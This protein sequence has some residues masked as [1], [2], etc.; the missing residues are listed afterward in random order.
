M[1]KHKL[2][3]ILIVQS[4]Q[5]EVTNTRRLETWQ[6]WSEFAQSASAEMGESGL[7]ESDYQCLLIDVFVNLVYEEGI[8]LLFWDEENTTTHKYSGGNVF[9]RS[10]SCMSVKT[11][12]TP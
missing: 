2:R 7:A 10:I 4:G 12:Q 3:M 5:C 6:I 1:V 9:V 8:L 11:T